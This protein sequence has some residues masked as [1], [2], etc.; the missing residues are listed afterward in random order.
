MTTTIDL[1]QLAQNRDSAPPI[2]REG[3]RRWLARYAFPGGIILG[4]LGLVGW[5][6]RDAF[7]PVK[8]VTVIPVIVARAEVQR[9]GT[10]L[11]QAAGWIEPRPTAILVPALAEGIVSDLLVVE[12]EAVQAGQP[13]ARLVDADARLALA[14]AQASEQLA[15]ADVDSAQA[16]LMAAQQRL[17]TPVHLQ[18]VLSEAEGLLAKIETELARM[19][20]LIEAAEARGVFAQQNLEGK[21]AA[22][23]AVPG[24]SVQ[25]AQSQN[26]I[27]IAE[28]KELRAR[29]P[30]LQ[31][32]RDAQKKRSEALQQQ[33]TLLIDERRAVAT[34]RAQVAAAR[35][36]LKQ[37][38]L[39]VSAAQLRLDR[40]TI[41][42]P[43]SGRVLALVARPGARVMGLDPGGE[44]RSS[45]V[46]T[47]YDPRQLQVRADVRLEDVPL[48][49]PGQPVQ[50]ETPAVKG[51][52][53]GQV[54]Q[55][56]SQANVQ[57]N[58]LEVKV[59]ITEPPAEIRPEM[60]VTATFLALPSPDQESNNSESSERLLVPRRL[61]E[62]SGDSAMTWVADPNGVARHR[63]VQL[64][65]AGTEDLVEVT[66]GL[67]PTDR[68]I[69]VGRESLIEGDR[70]SIT[71]DSQLGAGEVPGR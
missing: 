63:A 17:E 71:E 45:T 69:V 11:F 25:E 19:P 29:H 37:A 38:E 65:R 18:A 28:L 15:H 51:G 68:L 55:A 47:L 22:F 9:K 33:L 52:L 5:A 3:R 49:Q 64:G 2:R 10:P 7:I 40:M 24:R 46:L 60:L 21:Q 20:L 26:N 1:Q 41:H 53:A 35:S 66:A 62:S 31:R 42:A 54:L 36:R 50:I 57:K 27:A 70:L 44:N 48:V 43:I 61:V 23:N 58:T 34:A 8:A 16:E 32:E 67:T 12:G 14:Q 30:Q 59:A 56:T 13:V 39:Q 4:L 6:S